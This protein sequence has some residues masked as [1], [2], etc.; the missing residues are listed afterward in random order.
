MT[1]TIFQIIERTTNFT[2]VK[3]QKT[4]RIIKPSADFIGYRLINGK[5]NHAAI[6]SL[7]EALEPHFTGYKLS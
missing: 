4:L 2:K 5:P 7:C 1:I 3:E 6:N